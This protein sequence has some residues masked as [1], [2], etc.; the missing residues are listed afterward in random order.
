MT[1]E[2][3]A[4]TPAGLPVCPDLRPWH[5][6]QILRLLDEAVTNAVK[7][8]GAKRVTV[9]LETIGDADPHGR[10]TISDNGR[11][12]CPEQNQPSG[13][14]STSHRGLANMAM[15]AAR[16]GAAIEV[17]SSETGTRVQLDLPSRFPAAEAAAG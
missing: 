12:F 2:W 13:A 15:R 10:I 8:S 17:K 7:H 3:R 1:L 14:V 5:V 9:S 11:G 16:C 4:L 6:I